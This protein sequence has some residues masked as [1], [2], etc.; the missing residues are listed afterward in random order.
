MYCAARTV[1][2]TDLCVVS[3]YEKRCD[4]PMCEVQ[5]TGHAYMEGQER[6]VFSLSQGRNARVCVALASC[7][8]QAKG[9]VA[10]R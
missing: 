5:D 7:Q 3:A 10:A 2:T 1:G 6:Q 9:I 8:W 4:C